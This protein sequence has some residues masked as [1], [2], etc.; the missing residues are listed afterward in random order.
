M[1]IATHTADIFSNLMVVNCYTIPMLMIQESGKFYSIHS[2]IVEEHR[3][4]YPRSL[5][6]AYV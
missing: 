2:Y 3:I 1:K 4:P 6:H 5:W